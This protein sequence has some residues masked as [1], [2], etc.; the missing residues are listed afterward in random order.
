MNKILR[1][2]RVV[3]SFDKKIFVAGDK[4][5]SI[6]WVLMASL[7]KKKSTAYNLLISEDVLSA[8][9]C[10]K[11]LG[12][13]VKLTSKKCE[14]IG[15]GLNLNFTNNLLIDAGNSGTLG[16]L[17]LGLLINSKKK[18]KLVGDKSLS[19]RDFSRIINPLKKFGAMFESKKNRLPLKMTG[20]DDPKP[21]KYFEK[22]GSAQ[23]KSAVMFAGL[24]AK[25]LT[26]IKAKKSRSHT[27]IMFKHLKIPIKIKKTKNFDYI[28]LKG[29]KKVNNLDYKIPG[30]ISSC[31][32]FIV[33]TILANKSKLL[34]KNININDSRIGVIHIL[35]KMGASIKIM[36]RK[37]YKGEKIGDI[38]V[39]SSSNLKAINCPK[40]YNSSAIDEFLIIFLV[41]AK[42]NGIS[43]FKGLSELNKKESPR[44]IWGS[45]ILN[46]MGVKNI[47]TKDSIKIYG[48]PNLFLKKNITIKNFLKDHRVF[49]MSVIAALTVGGNW[50]INDL[51]SINTSFPDFLK[52]L[53]KIEL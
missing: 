24:K 48:N 30:D 2:N 42:S 13:K 31:S 46:Y 18:F 53:K 36:N 41:A 33:L 51:D 29:I 32:F 11:K 38:L 20:L 45:K 39:K 47:L 1:I 6:R 17:I 37:T 22:K 19:K 8:I 44:L 49:M 15:N 4:S 3:K 9:N 28:K 14:I 21:I 10:I 35:R 27:E 40:H 34:I 12:S 5:L 50:N 43:Y 16:R 25:G 52:I 7:S 23:C 26:S